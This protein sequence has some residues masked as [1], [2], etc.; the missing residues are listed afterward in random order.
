[1]LFHFMLFIVFSEFFGS[2][3]IFV[4]C[5]VTFKLACCLVDNPDLSL[6]AGGDVKQ[7]TAK[8]QLSDM[9]EVLLCPLTIE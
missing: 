5:R 8:N 7:I 2:C 6:P 4:P 1:M 9:I 3:C